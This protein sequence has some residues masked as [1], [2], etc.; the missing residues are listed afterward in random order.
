MRDSEMTQSSNPKVTVVTPVYNGSRF[1]ERT[2]QSVHQQTYSNIEHIVV[3]GASTD[4]TMEVVDRYSDRLALV[5]SEPDKG[6]YDALNKGF[7]R[8]TGSIFCYLNSDDLYEPEAIAY[9]VD[10]MSRSGVEMCIGDCIF[11]DEHDH[12]LFRYIGVPMNYLQTL[13]LCRIPFSQQSAFW[14]RRI[15]I[16]VGGFDAGLRYV[17]DTKFFY[18][19]LRLLGQAPV[20]TG[21]YSARFRQHPDA[22]STRAAEAMR[23]E[24]QTIL[25]DIGAAPS[26]ITMMREV[27]VKWKNR[28]NLWD[29]V[30]RRWF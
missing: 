7:S 28:M 25:A 24:H 1:I 29:R 5:I 30:C 23:M 22:F 14:T 26:I 16:E 13:E 4:T 3:D 8:A 18:A 15:H 20:H 27:E 21:H 17:A 19:A 12:E 2:L 6:M 9:A 11:I 10:A